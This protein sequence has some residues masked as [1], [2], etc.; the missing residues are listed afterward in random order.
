MIALDWWNGCRSVL[1]DSDLGGCLFGMTLQTR[2][3]EIYRAL[4]EGIAF[5]KE[6]DNRADGDGGG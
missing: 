5:G 3:E 6:D 1:M 2:P 4:M